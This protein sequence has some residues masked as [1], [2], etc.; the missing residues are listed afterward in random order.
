MASCIPC[1]QY[2]EID[3]EKYLSVY[4]SIHML[5]VVRPIPDKVV[6]DVNTF[7]WDPARLKEPV[8]MII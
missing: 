6:I 5:G 7:R 8:S 1:R 2:F 4:D 3:S